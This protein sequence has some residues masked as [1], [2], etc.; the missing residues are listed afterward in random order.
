MRKNISIMLDKVSTAPLVPQIAENQ[1]D[2]FVVHSF[3]EGTGAVT[4]T[5]TW[6]GNTIGSTIG[7]V[8]IATQTLSGTDLVADGAPVTAE[9]P[10]VYCVPS[11][12]TGTG[13]KLRRG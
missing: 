3:V 10:F 8:V 12:I 1:S 5:V 4:A 7:A 6:Y 9:W 2:Q 11:A 13:L